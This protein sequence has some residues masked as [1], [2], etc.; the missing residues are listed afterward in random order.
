VG[1]RIPGVPVSRIPRRVPSPTTV[2]SFLR[3][4]AIALVAVVV[5]A[6]AGVV[7][8]KS[9]GRREFAKSA[10]ITIN[11]DLLPPVKL[12]EPANILLLGSD[13]RPPN[14]TP[15]EAARFGTSADAA[16]K[17]SDVMMI[18]H[19]EPE[20]HTGMV[21]SFPRDLVVEIPGHS[22]HN[23]LNAAYSL[24]GPNLAI[25]TIEKNFPPLKINHYIE[26]NFR[27]FKNVVDAIGK[28]HIWFPTAVRDVFTQ[29]DIPQSGCVDLN[30]DQAL[31][32]ARSRHYNVP[33]DP[34]NPVPFVLRDSQRPENGA[35]GWIEDPLAD[36]DRIPRQQYFLRTL[37]RAALSKI[38]GDPTKI[39]SLLGSVFKNLQHDQ[40][41]TYDEL[42]Q[43]A[44]TFRD[45]NP[46]KI[47]MITLPW[48]ASTLP[49]FRAN[50]VAKYPDWVIVTNRLANFTPPKKAAVKPLAA[51]K[52]KVR[53]VN[54]SGA[55]G[56][57]TQVLD[58]FT[59]AGFKS[60]GDAADADRSDYKTQVRYAPGKFREG[61]TVAVA[62]GTLNLVQAAS[63]KNTLGGDA[64]LIVGSDYDALKH[65]FELV[66]KPAGSTASTATTSTSTIVPT[67]TTTTTTVPRV[68]VDTRFV[69]VDPK[70]GA[71]LVG[72]P[73]K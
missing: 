43:L 46:A 49:G 56:A 8:G 23:L 72:C 64:L 12:G 73:S 37:S 32:Y 71:A 48:A 16:G 62:V 27:G 58:S 24:G 20:S 44:V 25:E 26:V 15:E 5:L 30:G 50:V 17:R 13:V 69:P 7:L 35:R 33:A 54:G 45:L 51:D 36:L 60:A 39:P 42:S 18:L 52:V 41:L 2:F 65:H 55:K 47:Q 57:A 70:T 29:L 66:P 21:V 34:Q 1:V 14:E 11:D 59:A 10:T 61:Y 6:G 3:R 9:Y 40:K 63:A 28:V 38:G 22:G 4:F 31:A 19:V 53:V 68:T 67:T